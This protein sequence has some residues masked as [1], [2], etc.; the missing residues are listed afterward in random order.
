[1]RHKQHYLGCT[2]SNVLNHFLP[3][4]VAHGD[5]QVYIMRTPIFLKCHP[6]IYLSLRPLLYYL[7][8]TR[9]FQTLLSRSFVTISKCLMRRCYRQY[10]CGAAYS[11]VVH[12]PNAWWEA[13]PITWLFPISS[14]PVVLNLLLAKSRL[15]TNLQ[16][17]VP[18]KNFNCGIVQI[19]GVF[20][21]QK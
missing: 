5:I 10:R 3:S 18:V 16:M 14:T 13:A 9:I 2:W 21:I 15:Q 20:L 6:W 11:V 1:M 17:A 4:I 19:L 7:L 8:E 12:V